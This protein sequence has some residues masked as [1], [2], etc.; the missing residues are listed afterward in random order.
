VTASIG[1]AVYPDDG[2][3]ADSLIH[4]ADTAMYRIKGGGRNG[5]SCGTPDSDNWP[6]A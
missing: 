2:A 4:H 3:D 6:T 5:Y 1:I